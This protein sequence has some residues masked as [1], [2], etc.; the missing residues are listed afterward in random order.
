[1]ERI[2]PVKSQHLTVRQHD[3][4]AHTLHDS[5]VEYDWTD[6]H[7]DEWNAVRGTA[8]KFC[9]LLDNDPGFD[10]VRFLRIVMTG[11]EE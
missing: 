3:E 1:M 2:V 4:I 5:L 6:G 8:A 7:A 9:V 11:K 10:H